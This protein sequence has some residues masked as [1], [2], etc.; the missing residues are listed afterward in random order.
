MFRISI[1]YSY[2][3]VGKYYDLFLITGRRLPHPHALVYDSESP[4]TKC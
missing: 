2:P 4:R 1:P 3:E